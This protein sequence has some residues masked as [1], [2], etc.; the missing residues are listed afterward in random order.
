MQIGRYYKIATIR[1]TNRQHIIVLTV[2]RNHWY[3][4]THQR[5]CTASSTWPPQCNCRSADNT[6]RRK[7]L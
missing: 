4:Q 3:C 6:T 1:A 7:A 5:A 2:A